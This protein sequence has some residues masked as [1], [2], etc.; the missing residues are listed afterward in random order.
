[1][2]MVTFISVI[3]CSITVL[4]VVRPMFLVGWRASGAPTGARTSLAARAELL[5]DAAR[6]NTPHRSHTPRYP[7]EYQLSQAL[8]SRCQII[9]GW[10]YFGVLILPRLLG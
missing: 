9:F 4:L 5:A 7:G 10:I 1:M 8:E 3:W 6:C 2:V